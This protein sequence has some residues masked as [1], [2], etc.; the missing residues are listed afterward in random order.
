M[1]RPGYFD[2][3]M[4]LMIY[5]FQGAAIQVRTIKPAGNTCLTGLFCPS[6]AIGVV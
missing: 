5:R 1:P 4:I 3:R 6:V 2:H